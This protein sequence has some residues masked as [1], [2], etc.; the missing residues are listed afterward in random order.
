MGTTRPDSCG[1]EPSKEVRVNVLFRLGPGSPSVQA[2]AGPGPGPA[3]LT[4]LRGK[5]QGGDDES[6]AEPRPDKS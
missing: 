1:L 6:D 2:Q 4:T 5:W 3:E